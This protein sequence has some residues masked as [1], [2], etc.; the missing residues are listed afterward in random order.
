MP[1]KYSIV[2]SRKEPELVINLPFITSLTM[3]K[4]TFTRLSF[5]L[6]C[7]PFDKIM[8]CALSLNESKSQIITMANLNGVYR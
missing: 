4:A 7:S 2:I 1:N 6:N 8:L 3:A 5:A